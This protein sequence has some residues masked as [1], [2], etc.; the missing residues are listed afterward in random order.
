MVMI[1]ASTGMDELQQVFTL[2]LFC[3]VTLGT[4]GIGIILA[5]GMLFP[6]AKWVCAG[7]ASALFVFNLIY[8]SFSDLHF[9]LCFMGPLLSL[10]LFLGAGLL[11]VKGSHARALAFPALVLLI[12]S[13]IVGIPAQIFS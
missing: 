11:W 9:L 1:L 3:V 13:I 6:K 8:W 10:G 4:I 12:L 5:A 2:L 7:A